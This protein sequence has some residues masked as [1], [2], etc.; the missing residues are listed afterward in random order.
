VGRRSY[1]RAPRPPSLQQQLANL[2]LLHPTLKGS[3][4]G[5]RLWAEGWLRG[6]PV[7][8]LYRVRLEY[9]HGSWPRVLI[10]E[11]SLERRHANQP[12]AHTSGPTEPCLFTRGDRDWHAGM[13]LG[14]SIVPWLQEWLVFYEAWRYTGDWYGSGTLPESY[15]QLAEPTMDQTSVDTAAPAG[16]SVDRDRGLAD[17][18]AA[19]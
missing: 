16:D 3:V 15:Y 17:E 11:P 2:Q 12:V 4:D 7:T 13:Y 6:S 5:G 1:P 19:A 8:R 18:G 9:A 14:Q 10:L